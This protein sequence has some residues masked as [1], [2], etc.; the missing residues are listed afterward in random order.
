MSEKEIADLK[1]KCLELVKPFVGG[2]D[3]L[4]ERAKQLYNWLTQI[5]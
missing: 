2:T 4:L 3:L 1:L 5:S